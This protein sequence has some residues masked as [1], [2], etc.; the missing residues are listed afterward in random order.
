VGI[1][2][3]TL[4][5]LSARFAEKVSKLRTSVLAEK[6]P[7]N[8]WTALLWTFFAAFLPGVVA[9]AIPPVVVLVTGLPVVPVMFNHMYK[10]A[11]QERH[12]LSAEH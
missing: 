4:A 7:M 1:A 6:M 2:H 3:V 5:V 12:A 9:L 10:R 11:L 8:G